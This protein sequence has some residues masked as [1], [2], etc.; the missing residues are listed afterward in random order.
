MDFDFIIQLNMLAFSRKLFSKFSHFLELN[1]CIQLLSVIIHN[2]NALL[3]INIQNEPNL[4]MIHIWLPIQ[5]KLLSTLIYLFLSNF[6]SAYLIHQ[7]F[8]K[9]LCLNPQEFMRTLT[10]YMIQFLLRS[11]EQKVHLILDIIQQQHIFIIQ[12]CFLHRIQ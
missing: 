9:A 12:Y 5:H 7:R 10:K 8:F 2:Q 3:A 1:S 4:L 6:K 11:H